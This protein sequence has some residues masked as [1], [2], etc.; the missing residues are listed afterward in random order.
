M[1]A[2]VQTTAA[3]VKELTKRFNLNNAEGQRAKR[4]AHALVPI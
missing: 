3:N 1:W 2:N 4:E